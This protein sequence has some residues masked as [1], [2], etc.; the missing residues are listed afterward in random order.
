MPAAAAFD[1]CGRRAELAK[2]VEVAVTGNETDE[3]LNHDLI[4]AVQGPLFLLA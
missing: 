2:E 3:A 4:H 1:P